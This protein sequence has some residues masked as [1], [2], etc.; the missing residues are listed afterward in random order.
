MH[1][2]TLNSLFVLI[3]HT[4]FILRI[5]DGIIKNFMKNQFTFN[6]INEKNIVLTQ[7]YEIPQ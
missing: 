4:Q 5:N 1:F 7:K 3:F 2:L 6:F